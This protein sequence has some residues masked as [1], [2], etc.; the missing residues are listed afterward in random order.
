LYRVSSIDGSIK[1]RL[2]G[3]ASS[4]HLQD[5]N[6]SAQHDARILKENADGTLTI[7]LFDNAYNG[8]IETSTSSSALR[9][10]ADPHTMTARLSKRWVPVEEGLAQNQGSVQYLPETGNFIVSWGMLSSYTEFGPNGERLVDAAFVDNVT[11][12]YRLRKSSWEGK[13]DT[14][15]D[16]HLYARNESGSS[17][18]WMSWNGA[19][20][21]R[22]WRVFS[23]ASADGKG[24]L[25]L[26]EVEKRG[27]ETHFDAGHFIAAGFVE[28]VDQ[29]G[30][31]LARSDLRKTLVP[32]AELRDACGN[33]HCVLQVL[34]PK[35]S[36]ESA[37]PAY[38]SCEAIAPRKT[39]TW[40]ATLLQAFALIAVGFL[41]GKS[42]LI[43]LGPRLKRQRRTANVEL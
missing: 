1:W 30:R 18:F 24:E 27:F 7:S 16:L 13:P 9:I 4:F 6:F 11:R 38:I 39:F 28:A 3:P 20:E 12:N 8:I 2:G 43:E 32:P 40:F 29:Q 23:N 22:F 37:E 25:L 31:T 33:Q 15:P 5:F 34:P 14:R 26:G 41:A 17:H 10:E 36:K 35:E 21:V 19:T 42:D